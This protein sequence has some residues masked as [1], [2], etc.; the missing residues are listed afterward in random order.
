MKI[1]LSRRQVLQMSTTLLPGAAFAAAAPTPKR[2][3]ILGGTGFLGPAIVEAAERRG[4]T[5][6]L[7]NRGKTR[8]GLFLHIEKRQGD[9][10]PLKGEGI[11]SLETGEWDAVIDDSGYYPRMV[12]ASAQ[13]LAPR[14]KQYIYISSISCYKEPSPM[15]GDEDT[16][17]AVLADP[18]VEE[19]G[20]NYE[21][22]GGL[23]AACE[24]AADAALPGR[25]TVVRPGFIVGPDDPTGRFTYWPAR[26]DK[27]G[28]IAV[29]GAPTDPL[30]L[31][32]VRDLAEWLVL[33]VEN[34]T[35]G[36]F[37]AL[38]P[39]KPMTWGRVI[40]ACQKATPTASTLT[41][42]PGEF[43]AKQDGIDFPIWA[44]YVGDSKGFH[45]WQNSRAVK[46]GL[47]FRPVEQTVA[48]T[49][50]WYQGQLKEE[51]GR[52]RMAFTPEQEAEI[53]K[54]WKASKAG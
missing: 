39:D 54:R 25:T 46:A 36:K 52:T 40:T 45:T 30:Q 37:N 34:R 3:L 1:A 22:Y 44:P 53:L 29:P 23:K 8:P 50:A 51:K 13:L 21:N 10:D 26:F 48:D 28:E 35:T 38:G 18:K 5:L 16:P 9:R 49:L 41:W 33:M 31:I 7:F 12:G 11:K 19:M 15:G 20:K 2:I 27:G 6:T 32:D 14:V 47:R 43:V 24:A 4:H 17:L 42:I